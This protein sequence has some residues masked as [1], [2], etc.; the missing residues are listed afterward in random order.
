MALLTMGFAACNDD[1]PTEF[2]PQTN[3]PESAF[4]ANAVSVTPSAST[5]NLVELLAAEE[6]QPIAIGTI[7]LTSP[8]PANTE[9][10][11]EVEFS[12]NEDFSQSVTLEANAIENNIIS[13]MPSALEEAYY[14][15]ITKNPATTDLYLRTLLYTVTGGDAVAIVGKPGE[16]YFAT[17]KVTFTPEFL[18]NIE[19]AY[20]YVG[21]TN[22]WSDSDKTYKFENGGGD[23]YENPVFT[24]TVPAPY[25]EDGTRADNWF[26]IAP[27]SAYTSGDFWNNLIGVRENGD[28]STEG[29]LAGPGDVG[30]FNQPAS[31]GATMYRISINMLEQTYTITP[32]T[33]KVEPAYYYVGA[34]NGWSDSDK[35]YVFSNGGADPFDNPVYTCVVPAP[36][37]EDG[38]R[39]DNWFKIA[40]ESAYTSGD[41]WNNLFG[42]ENNGD[43]STSGSLA[44][45]NVGAFCQ[46]ASDGALFYR[47]SINPKEMTYTITPMNFQEYIYEAGVNNNW[48]SIAQPLYCAD[49][50][51]TYT[52]FFYAQ[53]ADWS[54]GMGAFKFTGAFNNWDNGNYG[55]GSMN[56]DGLSGTLIDDGNSGNITVTPGF[57]RAEVNLVTMT[58]ALTPISGIGIIGP[59]QPGGWNEDT[60]MTY[61]SETLA[62]EATIELAADEIKFRANDGWDINWGGDVNNLTQNGAN[63][64]IAEAGTY[65]IQFFPLCETKSYCTITKK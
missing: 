13:V 9:L 56:D 17:Q 15:N 64:K 5:I 53:D 11:A 46:P 28:T 33:F 62:W 8:L 65:F 52:G 2:V 39:A 41:F 20:Y 61:N 29:N 55:T 3:V 6:E 45:G 14:N 43:T 44:F 22:G 1:F 18:V 23:V 51:G 19:P 59:A 54:N 21:A 49:G 16:N 10:K 50:N 48:G 34:T 38:S 36:F 35:T 60:D 27:E 37:N 7:A 30:A 31:D 58:F 24:V 47:I 12:R 4:P 32:I 25:N 57:Y 40:P 26:K 63:I 42:V